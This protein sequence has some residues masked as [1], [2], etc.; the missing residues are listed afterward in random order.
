MWPAKLQI[1]CHV[2]TQQRVFAAETAKHQKYTTF[3]Y[4]IK[5]SEHSHTYQHKL[6]MQRARRKQ[7]AA[8]A[9]AEAGSFSLEPYREHVRSALASVLLQRPAPVDAQSAASHTEQLAAGSPAQRA[10]ARAAQRAAMRAAIVPTT[11]VMEPS[12]MELVNNSC[13]FSFVQ[14][15]G[16][17]KLLLLKV[18]WAD[19]RCCR[20]EARSSA[21]L[22]PLHSPK[23]APCLPLPE[24]PISCDPTWPL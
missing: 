12:V 6:T 20:G 10:K 5:R 13:Q 9:A 4:I 8:A 22:P 7:D 15:H 2:N 19:T 17:T 1:L 18:W 16:A 24:S 3:D 21:S 11:L 14:S 23:R